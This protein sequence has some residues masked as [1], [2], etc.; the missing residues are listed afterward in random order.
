MPFRSPSIPPRT[1]DLV[2][3]RRSSPSSL[4]D[5]E[6]APSAASSLQ[7]VSGRPVTRKG[8][9]GERRHSSSRSLLSATGVCPSSPSRREDSSAQPPRLSTRVLTVPFAPLSVIPIVHGRQSVSLHPWL[10]PCDRARILP[11]IPFFSILKPAPSPPA[12]HPWASSSGSRSAC[13][14]RRCCRLS[15]TSRARKAA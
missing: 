8:S 15:R 10:G 6:A 3:S 5:L 11:A 9:W 13:L 12:S 14:L 1:D 2:H 4:L 7:P